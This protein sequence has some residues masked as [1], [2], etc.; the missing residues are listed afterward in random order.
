MAHY[1]F[2]KDGIVTEVIPGVD[3][4]D[5]DS[6]PDGFSSWEEWY[7]TQR[8]GMDAC[9][10]TS[11]NTK[12][13]AHDDGGTAFR[14]NYAG[15]GMTYDETND[16]FL[17]KKQYDSWTLDESTWSWKAPVDMPDDGKAYEWDEANQEWVEK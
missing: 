6:L 12:L 5:T 7:L 1:A 15:I 3:E 14:G 17:P 10:R 11:Y 8:P 9:K 16:V 13:N 4:D 2:I